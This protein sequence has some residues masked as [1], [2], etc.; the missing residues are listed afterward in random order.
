MQH[1]IIHAASLLTFIVPRTPSSQAQLGPVV[2]SLLHSL[3]PSHPLCLLTWEAQT[4]HRQVF[5]LIL[6][7][8][9]CVTIV[10]TATRQF[11]IL[12]GEIHQLPGPAGQ[13]SRHPYD[14]LQ[15]LSLSLQ[16]RTQGS[17]LPAMRPF[18]ALPLT[19]GERK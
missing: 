11:T 3:R 1:P 12:R 16:V 10:I 6:P 13:P 8:L 19:V 9:I 18:R 14:R 17:V 15:K 4:W 5:H 7:Y 2:K